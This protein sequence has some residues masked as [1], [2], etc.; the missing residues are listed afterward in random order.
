MDITKQVKNPESSNVRQRTERRMPPDWTL[1]MWQQR[2]VKN[3]MPRKMKTPAENKKARHK[4][5]VN[6][7]ES[8]ANEMILKRS[9]LM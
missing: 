7:T 9:V 8:V 6:A 2:K 1:R 5:T 3:D 4:A